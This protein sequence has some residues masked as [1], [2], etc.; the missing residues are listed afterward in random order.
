MQG[1]KYSTNTKRLHYTNI[2]TVTLYMQL[3]NKLL[4]LNYST[5]PW[6]LSCFQIGPQG[7]LF[8]TGILVVWTESHSH[9]NVNLFNGIAHV[10]NV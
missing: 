9:P 2:Q 4:R 10:D 7:K 8:P 5:S 1:N 3:I 6:S